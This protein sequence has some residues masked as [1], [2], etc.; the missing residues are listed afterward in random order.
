MSHLTSVEIV[1]RLATRVEELAD[2]LND[3]KE[4]HE[5]AVMHIVCIGGPLND[6]KLQFNSEQLHVFRN[7]MEELGEA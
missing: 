3:M 6:N 5:K 1:A 2:E 4:R 7:I